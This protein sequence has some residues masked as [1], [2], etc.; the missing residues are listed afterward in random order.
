MNEEN[1]INYYAVIP[2]IIRYDNRLKASEKL[3]YGEITSLTNKMGYCYANNQ[4]F[5]N[6]YK[7]SNHTIS[8]WISKLNK[9][10]YIK[11]VII[12]NTSKEIKERRIY[13]RDGPYV[14]NDTYPYVQK[15]T[16]PMYQ[17]VQENN[18]D[19]KIDRLFNYIINKTDKIPEE[20]ENE[21]ILEIYSLLKKFDMLYDERILKFY[22]KENILKA[23]TIIYAIVIISK[24]SNKMKL[25]KIT[26]EKLIEIYDKCK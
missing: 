17:K 1:Q 24:S 8:Q 14:Q 26:R 7:V 21:N 23:K 20:L 25:N 9:L 13:I 6:L 5:A 12:R 2:A 4:Y 19:Y 18:I 11:V 15:N 22:S 3:L 16:Y 10:E